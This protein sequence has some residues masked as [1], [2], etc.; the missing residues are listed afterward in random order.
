M[1]KSEFEFTHGSLIAT[2]RRSV[3][4]T[5]YII[6]TNQKNNKAWTSGVHGKREALQNALDYIS[7]VKP[8]PTTMLGVIP[9]CKQEYTGTIEQNKRTCNFCNR[10]YPADLFRAHWDVCPGRHL[11]GFYEPR[12]ETV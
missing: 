4:K 7:G 9:E 11:S 6:L 12:K 1:R 10:R 5:W 3:G 2:V 8:L